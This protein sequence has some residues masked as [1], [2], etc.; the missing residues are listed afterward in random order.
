VDEVKQAP[1]YGVFGVLHAGE[2]AGALYP[3]L[4]DQFTPIFEPPDGKSI[5]SFE[6]RGIF[7]RD[8]REG[9]LHLRNGS[10][11]LKGTLWVSD[12]RLVLVCRNYD[13]VKWDGSN[14]LDVLAWGIGWGITDHVASKVYHRVRAS[15]KAMAA[16]LYYPWISTV[17]FSPDRGRK[18]PPTLRFEVV[19]S[20]TS[21]KKQYFVEVRL[22][23]GTDAGAIA[24][25]LCRRIGR[26]YL[27]GPLDLNDN[28]VALMTELAGVA[29]LPAP[30]QGSMASYKIPTSYFVKDSTTPAALGAKAA[31]TRQE[32]AAQQAQAER[33]RARALVFR[34]RSTESLPPS[35]WAMVP[36]PDGEKYES[37]TGVLV[38]STRRL[39]AKA[40]DEW[41]F[42]ASGQVRGFVR[43]DDTGAPNASSEKVIPLCQ[44]VGQIL[45]TDQRVAIAVTRGTSAAGAVAPDGSAMFVAA[46]P[47]SEVASIELAPV[48]DVPEHAGPDIV[49][50]PK[51]PAWGAFWVATVDTEI[52][53]TDGKWAADR[54]GG[55]LVEITARL[56]TLVAGTREAP[57]PP[58]LREESPST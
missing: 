46:M 43:V 58:S 41:L 52:K 19:R 45:V 51:D 1:K 17:K 8:L 5:D 10:G 32:A 54:K 9:K 33:R 49:I 36:E 40:S 31:E 20:L 11:D 30:A 35:D 21:G 39:W 29:E 57:I 23:A 18:F 25:S 56:N 16:H 55:D 12:Q 4:S 37:P 48:T 50:R 15:G 38:D 42:Q 24:Q 14:N 7:L 6:V 53:H 44:G 22:T 13:T 3:V 26:W 27:E 47:L 34:A 2:D 28:G